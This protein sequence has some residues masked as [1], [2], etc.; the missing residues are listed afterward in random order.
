[1]CTC[2]DPDVKKGK[3]RAWHDPRCVRDRWASDLTVPVQPVPG[4]RV[5]LLPLEEL[6]EKGGKWYI[7]RG[8]QWHPE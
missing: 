8:K 4:D 7:R 2:R 6:G 3:G 1:M 5:Q